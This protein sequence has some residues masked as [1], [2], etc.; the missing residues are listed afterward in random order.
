[1]QCFRLCLKHFGI[2]VKRGKSAIVPSMALL[3]QI[4]RRW[5]YDDN[6]SPT[7]APRP[8]FLFSLGVLWVTMSLNE[9]KGKTVYAFIDASNLWEAQKAKGKL[10][11]FE[12]LKRF[13]NLDSRI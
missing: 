10:F 11:D 9:T 4:G 3:P 2:S 6:S 8:C 7:F 12:K 1:M 5:V 13:L